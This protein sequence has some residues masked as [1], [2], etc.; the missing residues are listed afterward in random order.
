MKYPEEM[1]LGSQIFSEGM[2]DYESNFEEKIERNICMNFV[3]C[4][5]EC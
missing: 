5:R 4:N 2:D 3:I 1:Y